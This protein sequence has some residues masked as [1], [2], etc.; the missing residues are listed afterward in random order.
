MT[1]EN[2]Y[3]NQSVMYAF[4]ILECFNE[5]EPFFTPQE[6]SNKL[7][8]SPSS[9]WRVVRTLEYIGYLEKEKDNDRY[10]LGI[11]HLNF[12]KII[13][14]NLHIRKTAFPYLEKFAEEFKFNV[15]LGIM[16]DKEVVYLIRIPSP[17]I[18]D[19]YYHVGRRIPL[20]CTAL[21]KILLAFQPEEEQNRIINEIEIKQF[22]QNTITDKETILSNLKEIHERG[23]AFDNEEFMDSTKC[24]A[25]PV[26]DKS[27]EVIASVSI[28]N[29]RLSHGDKDD[30]N[31]YIEDLSKTV[32]RISNEMG[33]SLYNP[34]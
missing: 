3:I 18:P 23:Y 25:M 22:T 20:Y 1:D 6:L 16:D 8:I 30:V 32:H 33:Y 14:N 29:R 2:N 4:K 24:L 5:N 13:L 27:G 28:S 19:T 17:E 9:I 31:N 7:D 21:G 34:F 12:S 26:R 11:K 15:S 10:R